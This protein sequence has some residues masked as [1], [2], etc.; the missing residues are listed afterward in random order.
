MLVS[1]IGGL[2]SA[3]GWLL[4]SL[5]LLLCCCCRAQM[6]GDSRD[7]YDIATIVVKKTWLRIVVDSWSSTTF[8]I[9][10]LACPWPTWTGKAVVGWLVCVPALLCGGSLHSCLLCACVSTTL[11]TAAVCSWRFT[12]PG[13]IIVFIGTDRIDKVYYHNMIVS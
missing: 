12:L 1:L 2:L 5:S 9:L 6:I 4:A 3:E 7:W 13:V 8:Y 10:W 11:L